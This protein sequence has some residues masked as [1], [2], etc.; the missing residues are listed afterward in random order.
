MLVKAPDGWR[1]DDIAYGTNGDFG[2]KGS[3]TGT[4]R[5]AIKDGESVPN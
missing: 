3:L 2:N 1:V 5:D 4:L